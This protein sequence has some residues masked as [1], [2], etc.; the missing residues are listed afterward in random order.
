MVLLLGGFH[1]TFVPRTRLS[2]GFEPAMEW[3]SHRQLKPNKCGIY[4]S[5]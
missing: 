4:G 1:G 3:S 2:S 5:A